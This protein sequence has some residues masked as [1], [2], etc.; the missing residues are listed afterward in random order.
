MG[1]VAFIRG[2]GTGIGPASALEFAHEGV[3]L[4]LAGRRKHLL[5]TVVWEIRLL[6]G[7]GLALACDVTDRASV[8]A[9]RAAVA[10]C[11][12]RLE[13]VV[14]NTGAVVVANAERTSDEDWSRIFKM[15]LTVAFL[16]SRGALAALHKA[17][18]GSILN[19]GLVL[20][21]VALQQRAAYCA[22]KVGVAGLTKAMAL[23]HAHQNIPV[24]CICPSL[25]ETELGIQSMSKVTDPEAE[26]KR[27]SA[28]IPLGRLGKPEAVAQ[29]AAYL[30]SDDSAWVTGA[31][32]PLDGGLTAY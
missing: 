16:V 27:R 5:K 19:T 17:G 8:E 7:K 1:K 31:A 4:A 20:G 28:E 25:V 12:G 11:L 32:I 22:A 13:I 2:S 10:Q 26:R 21:I 29:L 3:S 6:D 23:D 15:N 18:D 24:N 30:P 14:N 9:V